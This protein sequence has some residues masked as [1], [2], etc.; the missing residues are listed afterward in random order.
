[1]KISRVKRFNE[2][3]NSIIEKFVDNITILHMF[4]IC[5][6]SQLY[7]HELLDNE[8]TYEKA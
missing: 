4:W 8:D 5:Y 2:E 1:M 3:N 6:K 7:K